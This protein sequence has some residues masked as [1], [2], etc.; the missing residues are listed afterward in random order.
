[1]ASPDTSTK[2]KLTAF[3]ASILPG[4]FMVG[5]VIGTGSVTTMA[6][7][8]ASYGT[9]LIWTLACASFFTFIMFAAVSKMTMVSGRTMLWNYRRNF[10]SPI[11]TFIVLA[12]VCSQIASIIGVMGI[13]TDVIREWSRPFT[14]DGSGIS[15]LT[16]AL[17]LM[18]VLLW[19]FWN[20]RHRVFLK[21]VSFLVALMGISF[22]ATA[23]IALP[24]PA[25]LLRGLI[26]SIP[27]TGNA[28]LLI[29][30]MV[31][32]T[33]ASVCLFARST[34]IHEEGWTPKD[35][36]NAYRDSLISVVLLF[37]INTA[38]MAAAAGTLFLE[39]QGVERAIDMVQTL[40]PLAGRFATTAFVLGIVAAGLTSLFPNYLIGPWMI[41]DFFGKPREFN[42][43]GYRILVVVSASFSLVIPIFGGSPVHIMIASQAVSPL[44]MPIITLFTWLL[45]MRKSFAG[46]NRNGFWMNAGLGITLLFTLYMLGIAVNGFIGSLSGA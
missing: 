6:S 21:T 12:L 3:A 10:G 26:P 44:V 1:M 45:L 20:G 19:L 2:S 22:L 36:P 17:V 4:I 43:K 42:S 46:E 39:G 25:E 11:T 28:Q 35:L 5:Y 30:G 24:P 8:G 38:I 34:V 23:F 29:A 13:V 7:A 27:T 14:S 18:G 16:S 40:E 41:S 37:I 15:R 31:G 32:T 9:S 33:L